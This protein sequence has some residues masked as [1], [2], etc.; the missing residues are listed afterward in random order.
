MKFT[1]PNVFTPV[2]T[3]E[4]S[5][6]LDDLGKIERGQTV[7]SA[8]LLKN[9]PQLHQNDLAF[10]N[11]R[12]IFP[13]L[14]PHTTKS[15]VVESILKLHLDHPTWGCVRLSATLAQESIGIS[16]PTVQ[17]ILIKHGQGTKYARFLKLEAQALD[18]EADLTK[19]QITFIER[20]NP[21]FQERHSKSSRPGELLT[22]DCHL[23]WC[24]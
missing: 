21:C 10:F 4:L 24:L 23:C 20:F 16:S 13:K 15:Y 22:R 6:S 14:H 1:R 19:E 3:S 9:I 2:S 17:K 7:N 12:P 18:Q 8:C 11:P 5:R